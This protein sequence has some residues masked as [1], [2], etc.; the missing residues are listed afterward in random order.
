MRWVGYLHVFYSMIF[1]LLKGGGKMSDVRPPLQALLFAPDENM[2]NDLLSGRKEITLR[3]G[4]RDYKIDKPVILCCHIFGYAV[5]ADVTSARYCLLKEVTEDEYSADGFT[6]PEDMLEQMKQYYS[7]LTEDSP[8]T[9]VTWENVRGSIVDKFN[10]IED[11]ADVNRKFVIGLKYMKKKKVTSLEPIRTYYTSQELL[12]DVFEIPEKDIEKKLNNAV[13]KI[14]K[15][16]KKLTPKEL[17]NYPL[18]N[19]HPR[20][21]NYINSTWELKK[22]A[23]KDCGIW[24]LVGGLPANVSTGSVI[25]AVKYVKPYLEDKNKIT[26]KTN[27][28]LYIED[29]IKY[30]EVISKHI[31]IIVMEDGVIRQNK[32]LLVWEGVVVP[33]KRFRTAS[34]IKSYK[35]CKYDID[36]G[37]H[38]AIAL[39]LLGITHT[40]ALVGKR[41]CKS[42]LIY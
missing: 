24:P 21:D 13:K 32:F 37:N 28:I 26:L 36:D 5:M 30:A 40:T 17:L 4:Y 38:R 27:R 7:D 11:I 1:C 2:W 12:G 25:D 33:K 16:S 22:I 10:E 31:P 35:K 29:M 14:V 3:Q 39:G 6:S 23:L 18:N 34:E 8:M 42:D 41:T 20:Y 15:K 9:V 19:H